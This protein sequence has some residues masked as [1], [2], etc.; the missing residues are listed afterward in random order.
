V[1]DAK[2]EKHLQNLRALQAPSGL[3]LASPRG[4]DTGYD[5]AWLRDNVYE[6]LAFS[7][8]G[9]WDTVRRVYRAILD[10]LLK[11]EDKI[12][13]AHEHKPS[14]AWQYIHAR[15][16]PETFEEF[17]EEW[18]NKQNDAIGAILFQIGNLE[19]FGGG[20]IKDDN[21]RRIIQ[22]LV[23]Y[24]A[25][26][27]YW[28]DPDAGMW[29][30]NEEVH[31]SSVGACVAGLKAI[32]KLPGFEVSPSLI[33]SG[34]EALSKLLPRESESKF[35]DLAQLSL[36]WPYRIVAPE[37]ALQILENVTYHLEKRRGVIRYKTDRYYNKNKDGWSEEAEW[38]FG[39][40]WL[41][42]CYNALSERE[43]AEHYLA[44]A[45]D[46]ATPDEKIPELYFSNSDKPNENIP[47]GWAESMYVVA[48]Q[49][50][51]PPHLSEASRKPH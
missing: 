20:F 16:S 30:E 37:M 51:S 12:K 40:S 23:Y 5:K 46:V 38:C 27:E 13:W 32:A 35:A 7:A 19:E 41:A 21:D 6:A 22:R 24:L 8:T 48:L 31:A 25:S 43:K 34:V 10:T 14:Y 17:W 3:F 29:E 45:G 2:I 11:H 4:V 49:S 39:L 9:D 28:H 44:R 47:L 15:Y 36:I 26:V 18:G 42:L 1:N 33:S 50:I